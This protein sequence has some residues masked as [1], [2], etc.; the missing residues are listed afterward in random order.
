[1]KVVL[2]VDLG[3]TYFKCGIIDN[4]GNL[5]GLGRVAVPSRSPDRRRCE[6]DVDDFYTTIREGIQDAC[7]QAQISLNDIQA[8]SYSSQ[9]N[10]F[11]LLDSRT[12]PLTPIILWP[13]LRVE[14]IHPEVKELW[15]HPRYLETTG[16]GLKGEGFCIDKIRWFQTHCPD[17]WT[18]TSHV[19][20]ISDFFT[21]SMTG[22]RY[23]DCGTASLLGMWDMQNMDYWGEALRQIHL[24]RSLLST[25]LRPGARAGRTGKQAEKLFGLPEGIPFA[26]GSLDHHA[27]AIGAGLDNAAPMS[28]SMGTVLAVLQ[29]TDRFEPQPGCSIGPGA[30]SKTYY[31]LAF[32]NNGSASIEWYQRHYAPELNLA[33]LNERAVQVPIGCEGLSAKPFM[34]AYDGLTGFVGGEL[35][36]TYHHGHYIRAIME[37]VA[38]SLKELMDTLTGGDYPHTI[39]A[40]GGGANSDLWLQILSDLTGVQFVTS[41]TKEPATMGAGMFAAVAA[42]W[43]EGLESIPC[44]F[45]S[46]EKQFV[47]EKE[48]NVAY[49][50][51]LRKRDRS[52]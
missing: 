44:G 29:S 27:A 14:E 26:V 28:E 50:D 15:D 32:N 52:F 17:I 10:S 48:S 8:I 35:Q 51:W 31:K 33:E 47:P 24:D 16:L 9:A 11:L 34:N 3:T 5:T 38:A 18:K 13:D 43:F 6:L 23:G 2:G 21:F 39:V 4:T 37:S 45:Q 30:G 49:Q 46:I 12:T 41:K 19:M 42:G 1:M 7:S 20:S 36:K 22:D 25:L 40:T